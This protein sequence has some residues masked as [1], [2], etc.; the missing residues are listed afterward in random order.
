MCGD[1]ES[2]GVTDLM[3]VVTPAPCAGKQLLCRAT[4][5]LTNQFS[6]LSPFVSYKSAAS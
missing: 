4:M 5:R 2:A 3:R 6:V 1:W